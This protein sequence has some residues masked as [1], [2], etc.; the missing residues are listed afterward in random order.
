M[1]RYP[2]NAV[3]TDAL[4]SQPSVELG[5]LVDN[6]RVNGMIFPVLLRPAATAGR[7]DVVDGRKRCLA[8]LVLGYAE[9]T[10]VECDFDDAE[11]LVYRR[12]S[13]MDVSTFE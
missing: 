11:A 7:F 1:K 2:L 5:T 6:I 8:A 3:N 12:Q 9:V 10:G 4:T 13:N